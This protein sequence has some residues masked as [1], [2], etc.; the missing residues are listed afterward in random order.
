MA[1]GAFDGG[2]TPLA[3]TGV[4]HLNFGT[5][6]LFV[7]G[8]A[9]SARRLGADTP[10]LVKGVDVPAGSFTVEA[11]SVI[12]DCLGIETDINVKPLNDVGAGSFGT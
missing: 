5:N 7:E 11:G 9:G 2:T 6:T 1:A 3:E 4:G 10:T 8:V 12:G